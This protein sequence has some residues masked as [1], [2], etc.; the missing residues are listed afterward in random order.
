MVR[1]NLEL[2]SERHKEIN[3]YNQTCCIKGDGIF[4]K[5]SSKKYYLEAMSEAGSNELEDLKQRAWIAVE[6]NPEQ[7]SHPRYNAPFMN[8]L[9]MGN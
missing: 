9:T 6:K 3:L 1:S 8:L 2:Y 5:N 4:N 7:S